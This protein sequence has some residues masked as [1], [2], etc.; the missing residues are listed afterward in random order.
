MNGQKNRG[1][2]TEKI[3]Q[4]ILFFMDCMVTLTQRLQAKYDTYSQL[5]KALNE[6]QQKIIQLLKKLKKTQIKDIAEAFTNH[7]RN[8]LKKDIALLVNEG[9]ILKIGTSGRGVTYYPKPKN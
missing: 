3:D 5:D 9:L 6:R 2:T 4:W 8:T 7:S 1:K